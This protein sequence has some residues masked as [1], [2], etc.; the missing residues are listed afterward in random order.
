[1]PEWFYPYASCIDTELPKPERVTH[2][3][4]GSA[5]KW[6]VPEDGERYDEYPPYSLEEWHK[7]HGYYV[8]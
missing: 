5:A 8:D 2:I 3:M 7:T 6:A 4:M 1:W